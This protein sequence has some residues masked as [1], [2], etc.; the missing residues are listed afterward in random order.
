MAFLER[1][2]SGAASSTIFPERPHSARSSFQTISFNPGST[3]TLQPKQPR[4]SPACL[5]I[6][7]RAPPPFFF[8]RIH[9]P[10]TRLRERLQQNRIQRWGR[11]IGEGGKA[12]FDLKEL[13]GCS[14]YP[15]GA[16]NSHILSTVFR[17]K[18]KIRDAARLLPP[19]T[20]TNFG[21]Q[22]TS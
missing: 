11:V 18:P 10:A 17:L 6:C 12:P 21:E 19:F 22:V 16:E 15:G 3:R 20:N 1:D 7:W 13:S 5:K 9:V 2:R 14:A 8:L 4:P